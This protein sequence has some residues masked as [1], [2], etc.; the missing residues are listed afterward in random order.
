[1]IDDAEINHLWKDAGRR[2]ART[3]FLGSPQLSNNGRVWEYVN[4][5]R[6]QIQL[7]QILKDRIFSSG[8]RTPLAIAASLFNETRTIN[9]WQAF[10]RLDDRCSKLAITAI[11]NFASANCRR[12]INKS[13]KHRASEH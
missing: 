8:E 1:M 2:G 11:R 13:A 12:S 5:D 7:A 10:S 9:L 4:P 6:E 3:I